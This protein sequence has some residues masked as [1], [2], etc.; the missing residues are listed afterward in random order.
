MVFRRNRSA[1]TLAVA[2]PLLVFSLSG[3]CAEGPDKNQDAASGSS[4]AGLGASSLA[5]LVKADASD[6][7]TDKVVANCLTCGLGMAGKAEHSTKV[8]E[9][10][11]HLCSD[12]CK[13][14][15]EDDPEKALA[16]LPK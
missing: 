12:H 14:S 16:S 8:G 1:W 15:V 2:V 9:Y 4:S 3:C 11:L 7:K 10:E 13:K 6:G 5:A